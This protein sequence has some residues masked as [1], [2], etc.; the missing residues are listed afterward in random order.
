MISYPF[1]LISHLHVSRILTLILPSQFFMFLL[2]LTYL[3]QAP[4]ASL[5]RWRLGAHSTLDTFTFYKDF[6]KKGEPTIADKTL[7]FSGTL[8][9][10]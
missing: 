9:I 2:N 5:A 8:L 4:A 3:S 7:V 6:P 1:S 10:G